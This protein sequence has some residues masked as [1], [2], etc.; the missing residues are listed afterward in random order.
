[1][2]ITFES[3]V[4]QAKLRTPTQILDQQGLEGLIRRAG[5]M[6]ID[7]QRAIEIIEQTPADKYVLKEER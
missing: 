5:H 3:I 4:G 2:V 6:G 1:M 7:R